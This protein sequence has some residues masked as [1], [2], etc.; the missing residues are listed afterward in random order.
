M[1]LKFENN[2]EL[3]NE[4]HQRFADTMSFVSK[5]FPWGFRRTAKGTVSPRSRF[6][7]IAIGSYLALKEKP[8]IANESIS[9]EEWHNS[10]EY[11]KVTGADGANAKG[12]LTG[13]INFVRDRLLEG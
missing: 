11:K 6:E 13:R 9:V 12:R 7:S 10:T 1:N 4:Y 8:E 5:T 3:A 2:P